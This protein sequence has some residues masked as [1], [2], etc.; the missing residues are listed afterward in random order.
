ML[1]KAAYMLKYSTI[2]IYILL[3]FEITVLFFGVYCK[4]SCISV[5]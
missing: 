1:T 4:M 3:Q 5:M 2:Y